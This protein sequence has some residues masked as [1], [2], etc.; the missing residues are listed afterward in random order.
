VPVRRSPYST[1]SVEPITDPRALR[2]WWIPDAA[3][4]AFRV[5]IALLLIWHGVQEHFGQLLLP[6]QRWG[7]ALA[8]FTDPWIMATVRLAGG[9]LLALGLFTQS[10]ALVLAVHVVLTHLATNGLRAHWMLNGGE[11]T[12]VYCVVLLGFAVVG[13]GLFSLDMLRGRG[14]KR[15]RSRSSGMT[16]PISPWVNR[17]IRTRELS[18]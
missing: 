9:A 3:F 5:A 4:A 2:G 8:P 15:P 6:G 18:R 16:V 1:T 7:G 17:Q 14:P 10:A 13:P 11:L 12:T